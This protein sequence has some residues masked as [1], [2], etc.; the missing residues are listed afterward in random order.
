MRKKRF[1]FAEKYD[2]M[3][4]VIEFCGKAWQKTWKR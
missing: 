4:R 1:S 3:N 2:M